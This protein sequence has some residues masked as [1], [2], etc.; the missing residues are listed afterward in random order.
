MAKMKN[1]ESLNA[2][3]RVLNEKVAY[4]V[5]R[6]YED[7]LDGGFSTIHPDID[8]L[9]LDSKE[10]IQ[11]AESVNRTGNINDLIHQ[12]VMIADELV[13]IDVRHVGDGYYDETWEKKMLSNRKLKN[14]FCYVLDDQDYFYSLLYHALIQKKKISND[15]EQ[16]L[17]KMASELSIKTTFR[18]VSLETL[19]L[20]MRDNN[21]FFTYPENPTGIANFSKVDKT[22][23]KKDPKKQLERI[24]SQLMK[25]LKRIINI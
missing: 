8:I 14:D 20:Y 4:L 9:C 22:M 5:L 21:Y 16:R 23:I 1:W 25:I 24:I 17:E 12:Q 18:P 19:Q 3:F 15:Y 6:N 2:F 11:I 7:F 10:F 13:S